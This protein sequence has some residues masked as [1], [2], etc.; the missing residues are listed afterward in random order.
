MEILKLVAPHKEYLWGGDK[1]KK[2]YNKDVDSDTIAETWE[3]SCHKDGHSIIENGTYKGKTLKDYLEAEQ[4]KPLGTHCERFE[5]FPILIKFIDAKEPLSVQVHPNDKY[6]LKNENQYGKTEMWYVLDCEPNAFLYYGFKNEI[7][8]ETFQE[9][10]ETGT[11]E[12]CL[13]KVEVKKGDVFF[14][15]A[16]TIHA[17]GS[18]ITIA[19]IQQNSNVTYRVYDYNRVDANGKQRE[20]HIDKAKEVTALNFTGKAY[21]FGDHMASCDIF[22]VDEIKVNDNTVSLYADETSFHSI[23]VLDGEGMINN[24]P[25]QKGD[26]LFIPAHFGAYKVSGQ[27]TV[28]KTVI[29]EKMTYSIGVDIGGTTIKMGLVDKYNNIV[30]RKV[31][32]TE[33][34]WENVATAIIK[35]VESLLEENNIPKADCKQVGMGCPGTVDVE[36]GIITYSNNLEWEN[37]FLKQFLEEKLQMTVS[38][39]NDANCAALGEAGNQYKNLVLVTLGTGVGGGIIINGKIMSGGIGCGELG[40]TVLRKGGKECSCGRKG[41]LEAYSSATALINQAKEAAEN[42]IESELFKLCEGNLEMMNGKIPFDAAKRGDKTALQ[43]IETYIGYLAEGIIDMINIFRPEAILIGGGISKQGD[44]L[45]SKLEEKVISHV[46]GGKN[47]YLPRI[48]CAKLGNDAGLI[49]A[50]NL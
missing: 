50:A 22:E 46:F 34:G 27:V 36:T 3:L 8:E 15:E 10:I 23:V 48:A 7:S 19:E 39:D 40:H 28:L 18:G 29:P 9:A 5:D 49:G 41:C 20:L 35:G 37:V 26:S 30:A 31:Y 13:N 44:Y 33:K 43:V 47:S 12:D 24:M 2:Y 1:L 21:N 16:R 6:A 42:D 25:I 38:I 11:L 14:I 45:I 32:P 4:N 17:I